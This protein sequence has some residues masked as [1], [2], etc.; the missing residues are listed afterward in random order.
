MVYSRTNLISL[1]L[2]AFFKA[3]Y[4]AVLTHQVLMFLIAGDIFIALAF[5]TTFNFYGIYFR[6]VLNFDYSK[7]GMLISSFYVGIGVASFAGSILSD[8]VGHER[9]L[10]SSK[11]SSTSI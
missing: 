6:D 3:A 1:L 10:T 11:S 2:I 4:K 8:R 9:A 7:V 5:S